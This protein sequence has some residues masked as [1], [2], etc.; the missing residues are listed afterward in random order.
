MI[1]QTLSTGMKIPALG[2]G[3]WLSTKDE[4][5]NAVIKAVEVGYRHIDTACCYQNEAEIGRALKTC[6]ERN[7]VKRE[8]LFVTT[9]LWNTFHNPKDVRDATKKSLELLQLD[10]VDMFLI[11]WPMG[12]IVSIEVQKIF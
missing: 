5:Y 8:D 10:Y 6:F 1:Y 9:K 2:L 12:Y 3:T 7:L 4:V 11:H